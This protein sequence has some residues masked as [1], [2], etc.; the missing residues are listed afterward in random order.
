VRYQAPER[1][2]LR[3][4]QVLDSL[5]SSPALVKTSEWDVV[6]WNR[7]AA[8]VLTDYAVGSGNRGQRGRGALRADR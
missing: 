4:Q 3:L 5:E 2:T 8:A 1:V 7:A 6:A